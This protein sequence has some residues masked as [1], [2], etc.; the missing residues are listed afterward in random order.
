MGAVVSILGVIIKDVTAVVTIVLI[1]MFPLETLILASI[2]SKCEH[3]MS[4]QIGIILGWIGIKA[5]DVFTVQMQ[6]QKLINDSNFHKNLIVQVA[7]DH[8]RTQLGIMELVSIKSQSIRGSMTK[9][10]QY[11]KRMFIDG[12]PDTTINTMSI[13]LPTVAS[14]IQ[15]EVGVPITLNSVVLRA[16]SEEE[17]ISYHLSTLYAYNP[18]ANMLHYTDGNR[19]I[20]GSHIYNFTSGK[21]DITI[22]RNCTSVTTIT[23]VI[24]VID[25]TYDNVHT[26]TRKVI[27]AY[28]G[29]VSDTSTSTNTSVFTGTV[30]AS[31]NSTTN[32]VQVNTTI[33]S[34]NSFLP[35]VAYIAQYSVNSSGEP[36]V[37][38]YFLGGSNVALNSARN[39]V[40]QLDMLPIV[41]LRSNSTNIDVDKTSVRYV[42]S[43]KILS[44][45]GIDVDTL[46]SAINS[47]GSIA[48][49]SAAYV[50]FGTE[51]GSNNPIHAKLIH[52]IMDYVYYD[53]TLV[54]GATHT[55]RVSE[56]N[57]NSSITWEKQERL[58]VNRTGVPVGT[59]EGG[60]SYESLWDITY[61]T[62]G[63]TVLSSAEKR[64]YYGFSRK[65]VTQW[66]YVEYRVYNVSAA[67]L[68]KKGAMHDMAINILNENSTIVIPM[69]IHFLKDFTA[70]EQGAMLPEV[71]RM[72]TYAGTVTHLNYYQTESFFKLVQVVVIIIAIVAFISSL[73]VGGSGGA[74]WLAFAEGVLMTMAVGFA[75]M[76]LLT[77]IDNPYIKVVV[78]MAIVAIM[79]ANGYVE[80]NAV[81]TMTITANIITEA[82]TQYSDNLLTAGYAALAVSSEAFNKAAESAKK[83]LD[84]ANADLN[85][86]ALSTKEVQKITSLPDMK[87][88][89]EG[90]DLMRYKAGTDFMCNWELVKS[91]A[92]MVSLYDYDLHFRLG[93]VQLES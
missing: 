70:I 53:P 39:Y 71:L 51:L 21:F 68:I 83:I 25:T 31:E 33:V 93:V 92:P 55:I 72:V 47:N 19:Y 77:Y 78:A 29:I 37:W 11:G 63:V 84:A 56:G 16:P 12:E 57:Y 15:L 58:T 41:E 67:T 88:Y 28:E 65:Q 79:A 46:L 40:T 10:S 50:Y 85:S 23:K 91:M 73:P 59:Y 90:Y 81:N 30:L 14:A 86:S 9:Y 22:T 5:E 43:K 48:G 54:T 74:A 44:I 87:A 69:S 76:K 13:D 52:N 49:V 34:I 64:S 62:D 36:R 24:S 27:T 80:L 38:L 18:A 45:I 60:V 82:V 35:A 26:T 7:L 75:I 66:A 17:W 6:D 61:A 32:N 42:Q 1:D 2:C 8:Q 4:E 20:L 3:F 89:V